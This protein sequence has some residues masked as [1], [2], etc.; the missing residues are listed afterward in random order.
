MSERFHPTCDRTE[1]ALL[2]AMAGAYILGFV[3]VV[4]FMLAK[5]AY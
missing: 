5:L 1:A 4:E 3:A 2:V